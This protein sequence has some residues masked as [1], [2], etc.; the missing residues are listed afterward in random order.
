MLAIHSVSSLPYLA[1]SNTHRFE[2]EEFELYT[3]ILSALNWRKLNGDIIM[4]TDDIAFEYYNKPSLKGI[5]SDIRPIISNDLEGINPKMFWA[6]AKLLAL[7]EMPAPIVMMDTD[8]IVWEKLNLK[9]VIT[10]AHYEDINPDIYPDFSLFETNDY[11]IN[12]NWSKS[13]LPLNTCFLYLP[14]EDF[15]QYYVNKSIEFMKFAVECDDYL[16]RMV[17]AEQ[18]LLSI[19]ADELKMPIEVLMDKLNQ[20]RFT[21]LWGAKRVLRENAQIKGE[22]LN[23]CKERIRNDFPGVFPVVSSLFR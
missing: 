21:H 6:A 4:L 8:F 15:K 19:C 7:R 18:R 11:S 12:P 5:W 23:K 14:D 3:A 1:K 17:F 13:V 20:N 9:P 10:A 16:C 2:V 22:F